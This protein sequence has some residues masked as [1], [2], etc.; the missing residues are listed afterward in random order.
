MRKFIT[1]AILAGMIGTPVIA[2]HRQPMRPAPARHEPMRP[3]FH[4][5]NL[6]RGHHWRRG[7][8]LS[9]SQRRYVVNDWQRRGLRT[10]PR[11]YRW[12]REN[13]NSGD[14]LLV[15][16]ASGLIATILSQ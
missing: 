15:A 7:Q 9:A 12:L 14:Y 11:G 8:R 16:I 6:S 13:N 10:P 5:S 4:E 3:A 1:L 2:Q